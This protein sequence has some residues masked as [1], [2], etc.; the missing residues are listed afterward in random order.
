MEN[1]MQ[2]QFNTDHNIEGREALADKVRSV[3]EG[4]LSRLSDHIT[5]VEV[6]LSD[7]NS[8]KKGGNDDMR[9]M[10]EARLEGRQPIAVT[11]WAATLDQA[12]DG[13]ADKLTRLIESTLGRLRDQKSHRTDPPPPGSKLPEE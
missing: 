10:M 12:V 11:H 2:V 1:T 3:V 4:A 9:C 8:A 5:R 13:A 6:H 7:E